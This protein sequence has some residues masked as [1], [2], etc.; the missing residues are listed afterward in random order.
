MHFWSVFGTFLGAASDLD[1]RSLATIFDQKSK[2]GVQEGIQKSMHQKHGKMMPKRSKNGSKMDA[3]IDNFSICLRKGDFAKLCTTL[4]RELGSEG[5]GVPQIQEK[6]KG[7][8]RA[9]KISE[10]Y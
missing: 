1:G 3:K 8:K 4:E 10:K 2:K 9:Q 7:E 5:L 6:L